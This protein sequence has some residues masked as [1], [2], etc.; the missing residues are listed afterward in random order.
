MSTTTYSVPVSGPSPVMARLRSLALKAAAAVSGGWRAVRGAASAVFGLA[1]SAASAGLA[2]LS[3][4]S[5]YRAAIGAARVAA[6]TAWGAVGTLVRATGSAL[7]WIGSR[8]TGAVAAV[9]PKAAAVL[10]GAAQRVAAPVRA[11]WQRT[12]LAVRTVGEVAAHLASTP[13]VRR[14]TTTAARIATLLLTVHTVSKGAVAARIVRLLPASMDLVVKATNPAVALLGVLAAA[15]IGMAVSLVRLLAGP[16]GA[17]D[18]DPAG[19]VALRPV[20]DLAEGEGASPGG[21]APGDAAPDQGAAPAPRIAE[22]LRDLETIAAKVRVEVKPDGSVIVHGIPGTVP[23]DLGRAVAEIA[24]DAV[25]R[26]LRRILP[27]RPT[28]S[29]DDRRLFTKAAREAIQAEARRRQQ[30]HEGLAA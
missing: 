27:V 10:S 9:S 6:A 13:L 28:P 1:R 11:A 12:D 29:R 24:R 14:A 26:H 3:S 23:P 7:A 17:P 4:S 19:A 16:A 2:V 21:P 30:E 22:V 5:G 8:I 18:D 20:A 15:G 25:E